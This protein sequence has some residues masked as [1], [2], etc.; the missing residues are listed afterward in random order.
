MQKSKKVSREN[1]VTDFDQAGKSG[2]RLGAG[3]PSSVGQELESFGLQGEEG[4]RGASDE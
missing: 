2:C 4:G 1:G 3:E